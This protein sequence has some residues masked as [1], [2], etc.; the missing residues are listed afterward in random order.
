MHRLGFL[1]LLLVP[2]Q[3][4]GESAEPV[5]RLHTALLEAMQ[6]A[7]HPTREAYLR[8]V[9]T[10]TFDA[11]RIAG[12]SL[13]RTWRSLD[14]VQRDDFVTLLMDLVVAT[15]ADRFDRY[16][17]QRFVTDAV[18][19]VQANV[20]VQT[21]L[22]RTDYVLKGGRIFN[23]IAD[24]VSDLSLRRADY[25][26]ILKQEGYDSLVQHLRDKTAAAR[27]G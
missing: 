6:M 14:D 15:Y 23:V 20:V 12:I 18:E 10:D 7:D 24:G 5:E 2:L 11:R 27:N 13:G 4:Y 25:N 21:R 9:I 22:L 26:S 8:P 1:L 17:D 16:N 3:G 19:T